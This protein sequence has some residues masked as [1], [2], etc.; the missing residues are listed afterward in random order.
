MAKVLHP[1][2]ADE[3]KLTYGSYAIALLILVTFLLAPPRFRRARPRI[4]APVASVAV[5]HQIPTSERGA[6][7][8]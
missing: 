2:W 8:P 1:D 7:A 6:L 4:E 5:E 3:E